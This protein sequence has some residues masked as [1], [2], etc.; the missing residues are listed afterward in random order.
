MTV[1][2]FVLAAALLLAAGCGGDTGSP[3]VP[4]S[5]ANPLQVAD[6]WDDYGFGDPYVFR[7]DGAYYLY[8]STRDG[9][10]GIRAF[11]SDNLIDW[12]HAGLVTDDPVSTGAYAPEVIYW[13]GTFYLYT[14]PAGQG[15]YVFTSSS[16]TGPFVR[17]TGNIGYQIDGSVFVD[18]DAQPWF[19]HAFLGIQ[20]F[21]MNS[22]LDPGRRQVPVR[23]SFMGGWTE[24][25]MVTRRGPLYFLT[26]CGNHLFSPGYRIEYLWNDVSPAGPW[27]VPGNNP[28][29][30]ET[31]P[32][33]QGLGHSSTTLGPD[34]DSHYLVFHNFLGSAADGPPVRAMNVSR[35][36]FNG[37]HMFPIGPTTAAMA[38]PSGPAW[39][40]RYDPG[41][42]GTLLSSVA[43]STRF[44]AEL[45]FVPG[46]NPAGDA[47]VWGYRSAGEHVSFSIDAG[48]GVARMRRIAGGV[49]VDE[50]TEPLFAGFDATVLHTLRVVG[51][52]DATV[53]EIDGIPLFAV[54]GAAPVGK[55]GFVAS[56]GGLRPSFAAFSSHANGSS[57]HVAEYLVPGDLEAVHGAEPA[58]ASA[59][60]AGDFTRHI[61]ATGGA[62]L[63]YDVRVA[64][65]GRFVLDAVVADP[66]TL[67]GE[68]LW[69]GERL[70]RFDLAPLPAG[71]RPAAEWVRRRLA[72]LDLAPEPGRL[73]IAFERGSRGRVLR[74]HTVRGEDVPA[75]GFDAAVA[76]RDDFMHFVTT[77][78]PHWTD[79]AV[80]A[81][82]D[83]AAMTD[84]VGLLLRV[85]QE[86][87][88][89]DQVRAPWLGYELRLR[90]DGALGLVR[91]AYGR[92]V[93]LATA[94]IAVGDARE[95]EFRIELRDGLVAVLVDGEPVMRVYDPAGYRSGRV[96]F[97]AADLSND[98]VAGVLRSW[99]VRPLRAAVQAS[100]FPAREGEGE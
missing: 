11:R 64:A 86:S 20:M 72:T 51:D 8:P 91:N 14:S 89:P 42:T 12:T 69:N 78:D 80:E 36:A 94:Q 52:H 4:D 57:D 81:R 24:G 83:F 26:Y 50:R 6:G 22:L 38:V 59:P 65:G 27:K 30:L 34:L 29:V 60:S 54:A 73:T 84:D 45:S 28:I 16:P 3:P 40:Q 93:V 66:G 63:G 9:E 85:S 17:Q 2:R 23:E 55:L 47:V 88:H 90:A 100:S 62:T 49:A 21:R 68:I 61:D 74:L 7:H 1:K 41:V 10:V 43:T 58:R 92:Q 71:D 35:L 95:R 25:S 19:S 31:G 44:T 56:P 5:F 37:A 15:H 97:A 96:G 82:I 53:V 79:Y 87:W 33:W 46:A 77:G 75:A 13:N 48:T 99:Q 18:V 32:G 76:E 67:R 39:S 98:G 70:A